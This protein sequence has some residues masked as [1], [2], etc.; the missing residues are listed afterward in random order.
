MRNERIIFIR[1]AIAAA[2]SSSFIYTA[3][4][5]NELKLEAFTWNTKV[6]EFSPDSAN[7]EITHT[8][9][10]QFRH[11]V[12]L[13]PK[14]Y[15]KNMPY[16]QT[17]S[18]ELK[19]SG[20]DVVVETKNSN[21]GLKAHSF[22]VRI[23]KN[24]ED[25]FRMSRDMETGT[26]TFE[27][28]EKLTE[29]RSVN[30]KIKALWIENKEDLTIGDTNIA[31]PG[32][33]KAILQKLVDRDRFLSQD[34][35]NNYE[36]LEIKTDGE[37]ES[38]KFI[39]SFLSADD[40]DSAT[41]V[42]VDGAIGLMM[43]AYINTQ[44]KEETRSKKPKPDTTQL[45]KSMLSNQ[46]G[47]MVGA[48]DLSH[49]AKIKHAPVFLIRQTDNQPSGQIELIHQSAAANACLKKYNSKKDQDG[50]T[51]Y[52]AITL[53]REAA[54]DLR[55]TAYNSQ[56]QQLVMMQARN[57]ASGTLPGKEEIEKLAS[58]QELIFLC[59]AKLNHDSRSKKSTMT[60]T[61]DEQKHVGSLIN[62]E[63]SLS[64]LRDQFMNH[65]TVGDFV[66]DPLLTQAFT[67][68]L[69]T[70]TEESVPDDQNNLSYLDKFKKTKDTQI[71]ARN[72]A[73]ETAE[74]YNQE[75]LKRA[76]I[77]ALLK[78]ATESVE[79]AEKNIDDD[80]FKAN[81]D[82]SLADRL[83]NAHQFQ[84]QKQK[85]LQTSKE[86][87]NKKLDELNEHEEQLN[88]KLIKMK[89]SL[90]DSDASI[91][92][93][94]Q[95]NKNLEKELSEVKALKGQLRKDLNSLEITAKI[96][97]NIITQLRAINNDLKDMA[98]DI[99]GFEY[100]EGA[101]PPE[102]LSEALKEYYHH[103]NK[104]LKQTKEL[105][106]Q[107]RLHPEELLHPEIVMGKSILSQ[108]DFELMQKL[109]LPKDMQPDE[110]ITRL[111]YTVLLIK[112]LDGKPEKNNLEDF[113]SKLNR[114]RENF[115]QLPKQA[116]ERA[117]LKPD[118]ES[119]F[120]NLIK[121]RYD[122]DNTEPFFNVFTIFHEID[123][124]KFLD[125]AIKLDL[126]SQ[127]GDDLL[128]RL[129]KHHIMS[130][131]IEDLDYSWLS[132]THQY[133][134]LEPE[135]YEKMWNQLELTR[136]HQWLHKTQLIPGEAELNDFPESEDFPNEKRLHA[137]RSI[138]TYSP[139]LTAET[140]A[141]YVQ[142]A[143]KLMHKLPDEQVAELQLQLEQMPELRQIE[144]DSALKKQCRLIAHS[145]KMPNIWQQ[146][147]TLVRQPADLWKHTHEVINKN[148][149]VATFLPEYVT[150]KEMKLAKSRFDSDT[151][152]K[153]RRLK[154]VAPDT[155]EARLVTQEKIQK[156]VD[157]RIEGLKQT[158]TGDEVYTAKQL[159]R[160]P[161]NS[162]LQN[163]D[164]QEPVK[165]FY[166]ELKDSLNRDQIVQYARLLAG[167]SEAEYT[168]LINVVD[169][170]TGLI[171]PDGKIFTN[172]QAEFDDTL[173]EA[174]LKEKSGA[175]KKYIHLARENSRQ[176]L[177]KLKKQALSLGQHSQAKRLT[178]EHIEVAMHEANPQKI[179]EQRQWYQESPEDYN[180]FAARSAARSWLNKHPELVLIL[181][182]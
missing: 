122:T 13:A 67:D 22:V 65:P 44:F 123:F 9:G 52:E 32:A 177:E 51:V 104:H 66:K 25:A 114:L 4:L 6:S 169:S 71:E 171:D 145:L 127:K 172:R 130:L 31:A 53:S 148:G 35:K 34:G 73:I 155:Y 86:E 61:I 56:L 160:Y 10:N 147:L 3:A 113:A 109:S 181:K 154:E 137:L 45:L 107:I 94:K 103:Q 108:H 96:A 80:E 117:T 74:N 118:L 156:E 63:S 33:V 106:A 16:L 38:P 128:K 69:T 81:P 168:N 97:D 48:K 174:E 143:G 1:S 89:Q 30:K 40:L 164:W 151:V 140:L 179:M 142:A 115:F 20:V 18:K 120:E 68:H 46:P 176:N 83:K 15:Q 135:N 41:M 111:R 99:E 101:K 26:T 58:D 23:Q 19:Q 50:L 54:K 27:V 7:I 149:G 49:L 42:D 159:Q 29:G 8:Q 162:D 105:T 93:L 110:I 141:N 139:E 129:D 87:T 37:P 76:E 91:A 146:L 163:N 125:Y 102:K 14:T 5:S 100:E 12:T 21:D 144:D 98:N 134:H 28:H 47:F 121:T 150:V 133:Y 132:T 24:K 90:E 167:F 170:V 72:K 57:K 82:T 39:N 75:K 84:E 78:K 119:N 60:L 182:P 88:K 17:L 36:S 157:R 112:L 136:I 166:M 161:D 59:N 126:T 95:V 55:N 62:H 92:Q 173:T 152:I 79:E 70:Q 64:Y 138:A 116:G 77:E 178:V 175:V 153:T 165:A 43:T 85:K 2:I 11:D 131:Q 124:R 180:T 158:A